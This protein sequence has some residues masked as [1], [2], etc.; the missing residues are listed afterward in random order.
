MKPQIKFGCSKL[1]FTSNSLTLYLTLPLYIGKNG[2][3][4]SKIPSN[5]PKNDFYQKKQVATTEHNSIDLLFAVWSI[6][7]TFNY[8]NNLIKQ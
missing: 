6:K 2:K 5:Y 8:L 1:T 3:I 7:S 4:S